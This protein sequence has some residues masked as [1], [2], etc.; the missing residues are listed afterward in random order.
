MAD[1]VKTI[2]TQNPGLHGD[3]AARFA[4][5]AANVYCPTT[6]AANVSVASPPTCGC[7]PFLH[8]RH[9]GAG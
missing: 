1:I 8:P 3:N 2:Q 5:I 4:A 7:D 6:L 9:L